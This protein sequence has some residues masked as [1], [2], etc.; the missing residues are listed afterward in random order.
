MITFDDED[1]EHENFK[2]DSN[3]AALRIAEILSE[4]E[5]RTSNAGVEGVLPRTDGVHP[6]AEEITV[7][8]EDG[9]VTIDGYHCST[10]SCSW[11]DGGEG[12]EDED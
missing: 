1:F 10:I 9:S 8:C 2:I 3:A 6:H 7:E 12:N 4:A 5:Y 11:E